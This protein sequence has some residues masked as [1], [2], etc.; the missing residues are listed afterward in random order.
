MYV[1]YVVDILLVKSDGHQ[2]TALRRTALLG[3]FENFDEKEV[4]PC[5]DI[6]FEMVGDPDALLYDTVEAE[7]FRVTL[8]Y[9]EYSDMVG[10]DR[11]VL[12][13]VLLP[14]QSGWKNIFIA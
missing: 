13:P 4:L 11:E 8:F 7:R 6:K 2:V 12:L 5:T 14:K 10:V 3:G 9:V 1:S